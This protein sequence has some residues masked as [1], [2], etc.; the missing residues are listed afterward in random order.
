MV[1]FRAGMNAPAPAKIEVSFQLTIRELYK[2]SAAVTRDA[3]A[4][5]LV[6]A[7]IVSAFS[8][9]LG[10]FAI[11]RLLRGLPL[12]S[13]LHGLPAFWAVVGPPFFLVMLRYW[14]PYL[15]AR[16]TYKNSEN[17]RGAF[18]YSFSDDG[19]EGEATTSR[20]E[21]KWS[22]FLKVRETPDFFLLF[23]RKTMAHFVPKRAFPSDSEMA[24]FRGLVRRHVSNVS[25]RG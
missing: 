20:S 12:P 3:S 13:N 17:F 8:L 19:V 16:S 10:V 18:R 25:L 11:E 9:A 14:V 15:S 22:S 21:L 2:A 5:L 24:E 6:I 23:T 1:F 7:S 4:R